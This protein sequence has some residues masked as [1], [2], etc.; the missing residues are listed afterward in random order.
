[1]RT[2]TVP[3]EDELDEALDAISARTGRDKV[4][5][6]EAAVRN[7]V[8]VEQRF[9]ELAATWRRETAHLSSIAAKSEHPAYQEIIRMGQDA[10]PLILRELARGPDHWFWALHAITGENPVPAEDTGRLGR[11]SQAWLRWGAAHGYT[12]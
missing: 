10:I 1:M 4:D 6:L 7:Y 2:L 11:M 3:V 12:T 8:R 9:Q 5:L